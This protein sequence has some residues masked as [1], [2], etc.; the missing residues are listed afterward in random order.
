MADEKQQCSADDSGDRNLSTNGKS[1]ILHRFCYGTRRGTL[2][3]VRR[4]R[5]MY[6]C[7]RISHL[8]SSW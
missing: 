8:Q 5:A 1:N 3:L 6:G 2:L 4:G 7:S